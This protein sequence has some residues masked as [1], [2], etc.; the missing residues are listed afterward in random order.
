M[1]SEFV[2]NKDEVGHADLLNSH[3]DIV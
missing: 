1:R 3:P 2:R